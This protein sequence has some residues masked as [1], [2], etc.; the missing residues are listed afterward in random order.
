VILEQNHIASS[1]NS[2]ISFGNLQNC[3]AILK[4]ALDKR[5]YGVER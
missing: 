2:V 4:R 5:P 1:D 3:V